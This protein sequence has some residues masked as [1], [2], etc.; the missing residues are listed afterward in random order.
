VVNSNWNSKQEVR[1]SH[2]K[3]KTKTK[4]KKK[5]ELN[6]DLDIIIRRRT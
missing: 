1:R 5:D 2:K 3:E 4:N 6:S